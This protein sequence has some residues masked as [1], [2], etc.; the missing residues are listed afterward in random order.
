[1]TI[2]LRPCN[3]TGALTNMYFFLAAALG[4]VWCMTARPGSMTTESFLLLVGAGALALIG[5]IDN[6]KE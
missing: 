3:P 6:V 1:M 2:D 5:V 4:A